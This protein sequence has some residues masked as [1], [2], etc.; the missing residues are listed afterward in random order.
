MGK[1]PV[2][3]KINSRELRKNQ[4]NAE[5]LLWRHLRTRRFSNFRFRRQQVIGLYI[6]DFYCSKAKL[7]IELDGGQHELEE[8]ILYDQERTAFL[9]ACGCRVIRFW[10]NDVIKNIFGVLTVIGE[11]L[12]YLPSPQPSPTRGEGRKARCSLALLNEGDTSG[13]D[14]YVGPLS[15][16]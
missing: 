7:I 5:R 2:S 3:L 8:A 1:L 9:N 13:A 14:L 11:K 12:A 6:V 15:I 16:S 10:N 4:T